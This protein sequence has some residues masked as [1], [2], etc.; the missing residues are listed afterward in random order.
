MVASITRVQSHINFSPE[1]N[2]ITSK[3]LGHCDNGAEQTNK[4]SGP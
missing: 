4:L 3:N 2:N 1:Y